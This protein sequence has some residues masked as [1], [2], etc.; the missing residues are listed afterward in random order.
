MGTG[1]AAGAEPNTGG[2]SPATAGGADAGVGG[3][4]TTPLEDAGPS[5]LPT[6]DAMPTEPEV[7]SPC[8]GDG[9]ACEIMPLGD[10]ITFGVGSSGAGGGYRVQLFRRALADGH[11]VTFVGTS[12]PNGP[13]TVEGQTFPKA[14]QGHSGYA[15]D[16]GGF[17]SL[18]GVLDGALAT[19]DPHIILLMIGTNDINGNVDLGNAPSRLAALVDKI[20]DAEPDAL[21]V[22]AK[23]VP[24]TDSGINA[25]VEMYNSAMDAIVEERAT[26]G[27][28]VVLVDLYAP[29]VDTP[30]F[31]STLM[32][33]T[34]HPNDAGY[35]V[36][37]DAWYDA[38][39]AV[40]PAPASEGRRPGN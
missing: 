10:S 22:L 28:H 21:L 32:D 37:A 24:T 34:L 17:G 13:D 12:Q 36:M 11:V 18:S 4:A 3:A 23:I 8:P 38:I 14:N 26:A 7:Y 20:V 5:E 19:T 39:E 30:N 29:F 2:M 15:I 27:K 1:G 6:E 40:L 31:Q 33:D 16:Q 25:R 35:V 9:A